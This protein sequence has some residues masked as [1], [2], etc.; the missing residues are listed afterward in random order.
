MNTEQLGRCIDAYGTDIYAFCSRI[1]CNKQEADDLYQDTFLKAVELGE[2]IDDTN[3]PKSYLV[4]IAMRI[5]K[6]KKRKFAW[7]KRI[8]EEMAL[9]EET[10]SE[11]DIG[12]S[13]TMGSPEEQILEWELKAQVRQAVERLDEKY[14]MPIFLYYTMEFS[15]EQIAEIMKLPKGTVKSRLYKARKL[16][17]QE[18]EVVLNETGK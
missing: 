10:V 7:R 12:L 16:L 14:R 4:S 18:L 5:W 3:N 15:L 11:E 6:N 1:T 2:K 13:E 17:K 8:A 9:V